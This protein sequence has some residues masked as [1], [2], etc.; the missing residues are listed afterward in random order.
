[1]PWIKKGKIYKPDG[2]LDWSVSHAQ[3]PVPMLINDNKLRI[4]FSTRD[5]LG[6]SQPTFIE[7]KINKPEEILY[8]H[9][10]PLWEFG[11]RGTFDDNGIMP[12]SWIQEDNNII[13]FYVGWNRQ[14]TTAYHLSAGAVFSQ[15]GGVTFNKYHNGPIFDRDLVDPIWSTIPCVIKEG[16][17]YRAWYISCTNWKDINGKFEPVYHVKYAE[18]DNI[19]QWI[20]TNNVC[21][22]YKYDGEAIGRPWVIYED[23]IYKM[24]YSTRGSIGY[25]SHDGQHYQIGYAESSNGLHWRR[26][27]HLAVIEGS[28]GDWDKEMNC[29]ASVFKYEGKKYLLYNGNGF[30]RDGFGYAIWQD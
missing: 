24:W 26:L 28:V 6:R 14:V 19:F 4:Y 20:K 2:S 29:Y 10:K 7:V 23:D 25:R 9:D 12:A 1:M 3:I 15:D 18:S 5:E 8:I 13:M 17:K 30:G 22:D 21:I 27:D 16:N 11:P